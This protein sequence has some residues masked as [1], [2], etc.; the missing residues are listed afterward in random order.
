MILPGDSPLAVAHRGLLAAVTALVVEQA[1]G[2]AFA[3]EWWQQGVE[4][5]GGERKT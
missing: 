2:G 4:Q 3:M 1:L 5:G